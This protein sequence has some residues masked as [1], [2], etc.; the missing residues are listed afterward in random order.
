MTTISKSMSRAWQNHAWELAPSKVRW[1][2]PVLLPISLLYSQLSHWRRICYQRNLLSSASVTIPVIS[3]GNLTTGGSGKTPLAIY[4]VNLLRQQGFRPGVL[5]RGYRRHSSEDIVLSRDAFH[6]HRIREY[7]DEAALMLLHSGAPVGISPQRAGMAVRLQE[8]YQ[9]NVLVLDDGFQHR[10][11]QRD[12]DLVILDGANPFGNQYCLPYGPLREPVSALRDASAL[13]LRNE[14]CTV[15]LPPDDRPRFRG[16]LNWLG[17]LPFG[18]WREW[19]E[20]PLTELHDFPGK[21]VHLLS[22]IGKP[23]QLERQAQAMGFHV[24]EHHQFPDHHWFSEEELH[25]VRKLAQ[26]KPVL[27]TEKDAIRLLPLTS[28]A[29]LQ[30][31]FFIIRARWQMSQEHEFCRWLFSIIQSR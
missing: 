4:L 29:D 25:A 23:A 31:S 7:G 10:A 20:Y 9:C 24:L 16:Q 28:P 18:K 5:M 11:L 2:A 26:G 19:K 30:E 3:I 17:L 27:V 22:G 13:I 21:E 8:E 6:P 15:Q 1:L 12:V 14:G